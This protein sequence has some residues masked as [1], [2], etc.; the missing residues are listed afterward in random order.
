[1]LE[2]NAEKWGEKVKIIG[3][4]VDDDK[5]TVIDRVEERKWKKVEHYKINGWDKNHAAV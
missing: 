1:M 2:K 3:I 5:K 4:S